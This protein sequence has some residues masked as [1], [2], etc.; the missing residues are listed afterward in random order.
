MKNTF[1]ND[2]IRG[3]LNDPDEI[4]SLA[5]IS[6]VIMLAYS[7]LN[8]AGFY[9]VNKGQLTVGPF[10]GGPACTPISFS[11]GVCGKCYRD[12]EIQNVADVHAAADHI[13]CDG[14][15]ASELCVPV[16]VNKTTVMEID[17]DSPIADRF[18]KDF[19]NEMRQ[20]AADI[21]EAYCVH[22]W[23]SYAGGS[24]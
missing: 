3:F 12:G 11:K 13:A 20:A 21:A 6:S 4:A 7:S 24:I 14:N 1:I 5:N 18:D 2:Q 17:L 16:M 10:Q 8:W 15:T 9:L 23:N 22:G 19:E